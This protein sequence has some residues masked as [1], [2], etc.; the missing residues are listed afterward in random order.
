MI[1]FIFFNEQNIKNKI[2]NKFKMN[3]YDENKK[4]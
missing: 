4:L 2:M 3:N 1:K